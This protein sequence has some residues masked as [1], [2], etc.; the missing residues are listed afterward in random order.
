MLGVDLHVANW[1][2]LPWEA[3]IECNY[4]CYTRALRDALHSGSTDRFLEVMLG[5]CADAIKIGERLID[6]VVPERERLIEAL[7][8]PDCLGPDANPA[9]VLDV[10]EELLRSIMIEA[11]PG[12]QNSRLLLSDLEEAGVLERISTPIGAVFSVPRIRQLLA[13]LMMSD[14]LT[15]TTVHS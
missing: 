5:I 13:E 2:L 1:P 8:L 14:P 10:A 12:E 4:E 3:A 7:R 11:V 9:T 6:V 15:E